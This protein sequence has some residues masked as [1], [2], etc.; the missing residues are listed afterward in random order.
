MA[1]LGIYLL[2]VAYYGSTKLALE[3]GLNDANV[4]L[5]RSALAVNPFI[6]DSRNYWD[7]TPLHRAIVSLDYK[8]VQV[9][10]ASGANP[11]ADSRYKG[12]CLLLAMDYTHSGIIDA[13]LEAG[14]DVNRATKVSMLGIGETPLHHVAAT[15]NFDLVEM[16]LRLGASPNA[17][18][19]H[20]CT[21]LH[22]AVFA[23]ATEVANR[24]RI[25]ELLLANGADPTI[26]EEGAKTPLDF[27]EKLHKNVERGRL[28]QL[29]F[30]ALPGTDRD[31]VIQRTRIEDIQ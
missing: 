31:K 30:D 26:R 15:G 1:V 23:S 29:L 12:T 7:D 8:M 28:P 4:N 11:N 25:V 27:A 17:Q 24:E 20:G 21:P 3:N 5:V 2:S 22:F 13:L 6:V 9:L 18:D 16:L 14:A 10:L 19:A